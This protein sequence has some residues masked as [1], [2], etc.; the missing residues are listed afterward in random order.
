MKEQ[1]LTEKYWF[2]TGYELVRGQLPRSK[3]EY[4]TR[5]FRQHFGCSPLVVS[6]CW[7]LLKED[8]T[9]MIKN[10]IE[11]FH[12][13]WT[14]LFLKVYGKESTNANLCKC[15]EKTFRKYT[16]RVLFALSDLESDVVSSYV[17]SRRNLHP[18]FKW[19]RCFLLDFMGSEK[20]GGRW[21]GLPCVHRYYR[22]SD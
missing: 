6:Q 14:L 20:V 12:L 17:L 9:R 18:N 22:C 16:R 10:Q 11:P 15:S 3:N 2:T 5:I 1:E 19:F 21:S 13:L 8:G 4:T 7:N